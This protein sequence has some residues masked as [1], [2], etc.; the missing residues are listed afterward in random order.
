MT[1]DTNGHFSGQLEKLDGEER[2]AF[3][4][5]RIK[6]ELNYYADWYEKKKQ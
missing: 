2:I 3:L 4:K 6:S 5:H 1:A